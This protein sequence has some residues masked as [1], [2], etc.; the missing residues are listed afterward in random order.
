MKS[1]AKF[2]FYTKSYIEEF[3]VNGKW[4]QRPQMASS[5]L[6]RPTDVSEVKSEIRFELSTKSYI[7]KSIQSFR[8][9]SAASGNSLEW[10]PEASEVKSETRIRIGMK[11]YI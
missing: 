1:E 9:A 11:N 10:P 6:Q 3:V 2:R 7:R 4:P 8:V 5:N